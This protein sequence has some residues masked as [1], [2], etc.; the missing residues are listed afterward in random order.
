[1]ST[2]PAPEIEMDCGPITAVLVNCALK[3]MKSSSAPSPFDKVGYVEFKR[4]PSLVPVLVHLFKLCWAQSIIPQEWKVEPIRLI[5]TASVIQDASN[6][7]HFRPIALTPCFG[8]LFTTLLTNRWLSFML[9]NR[10]LDS[11]SPESFYAHSVW[12]YRA[13][14]QIVLY[15]A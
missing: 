12:V 7:A 10:Y 15:T 14:I 4:C 6:P 11:T 9:S 5:A 8:K 1:M 3:R 2:H 13:S